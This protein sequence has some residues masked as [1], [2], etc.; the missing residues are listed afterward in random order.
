MFGVCTPVRTTLLVYTTHDL[1]MPLPGDRALSAHC[2]RIISLPLS[3][4][5]WRFHRKCIPIS[6]GPYNLSKHPGDQQARL[7]SSQT[8]R[9]DSESARFS[10]VPCVR[11][12]FVSTRLSSLFLACERCAG[13]PYSR[14]YP[15]SHAGSSP[16]LAFLIRH[17]VKPQNSHAMLV[18]ENWQRRDSPPRL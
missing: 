16:D 3:S 8:T 12:L 5:R 18:P 1:P 9:A 11:C 13:R 10:L 6:P 2:C 14:V 4:R 17:Q 7:Y 15:Y